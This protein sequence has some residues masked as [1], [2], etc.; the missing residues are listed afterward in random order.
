ME[1]IIYVIALVALAIVCGEIAHLSSIDKIKTMR[2]AFVKHPPTFLISYLALGCSVGVVIINGV[3]KDFFS[4]LEIHILINQILVSIILI[5]VL[6][7]SIYRYRLSEFVGKWWK[8]IVSCMSAFAI[9]FSMYVSVYVDAEIFKYS[10]FNAKYFPNAQ[11]LIFIYLVPVF[12]ALFSFYCFVVIY[13]MHVG[14]M[15]GRDLKRI[16]YLQK[17][18]LNIMFIVFGKKKK[19]TNEKQSPEDMS[20][21]VGLAILSL[22]LPTLLK[23]LVSEKQFNMNKVLLDTL[24]L[25]SYHPNNGKICSNINDEELL[26]TFIKND[27]L[28][29]AKPLETGGYEFYTGKCIRANSYVEEQL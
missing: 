10:Q 20:L 29:I 19:V 14:I 28:S 23:V 2:K 25:S 11:N 5:S 16:T 17:L 21:L 13:F 18:F 22:T 26:I 6:I 3:S 12:V 4:N 24:I 1:F 7:L 27:E 9:A 15:F 8:A